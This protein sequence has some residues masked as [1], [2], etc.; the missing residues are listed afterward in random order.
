VLWCV[1]MRGGCCH[2]LWSAVSSVWLQ[3]E[4]LLF[5]VQERG[6]DHEFLFCSQFKHSCAELQRV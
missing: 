4:C 2:E 3:L 6:F 5:H 1:S